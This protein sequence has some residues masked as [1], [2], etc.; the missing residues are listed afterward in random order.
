MPRI[1]L[2]I[3]K[4]CGECIDACPNN[5]LS[6]ENKKAIIYK[7]LCLDCEVCIGSCPFGAIASDRFR[8]RY[9]YRWPRPQPR[10]LLYYHLP[11]HRTYYSRPRR[12]RRGW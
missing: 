10:Y 2:D 1:N 8:Y 3:C 6:I 5:A 9:P 4:G 7:D 12:R 11:F